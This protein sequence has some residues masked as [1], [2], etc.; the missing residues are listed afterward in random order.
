MRKV[1]TEEGWFDTYY[2]SEWGDWRK[3]YNIKAYREFNHKDTGCTWMCY[4]DTGYLSSEDENGE[5]QVR[6]WSDPDSHSLAVLFI[7]LESSDEFN[8]AYHQP[9]DNTHWVK[10]RVSRMESN[11]VLISIY[12]SGC[13]DVSYT[14]H[15][16]GDETWESEV[17][18]LKILGMSDLTGCDYFFTN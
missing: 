5:M 18:E 8:C 15:L 10:V 17:E 7:Q 1:L 4:T 12:I 6:S 13:D 14:K 9:K 11:L 2:P 3:S 16:L